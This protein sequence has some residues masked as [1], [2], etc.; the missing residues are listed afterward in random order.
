MLPRSSFWHDLSTLD[1]LAVLL[2]A[3]VAVLQLVTF[4]LIPFDGYDS[5]SHIFWIGEWQKL[6]HEGIFYPRWMPDSYG[7][8]GAPSFYFYPPLTYVLASAIGLIGSMPGV[9]I[10]KTLVAITLLAS[11]WTMWLYLRWRMPEQRA[12]AWLG[13]MIF[14]FAPYRFFN[15]TTR[16]ALSEHVAFMFVPLAFWAFDWMTRTKRQARGALLLALTFALLL[17]TNLPAA[18]CTMVALGIYAL[19][20]DERWSNVGALA[21][22]G[23]LSAAL[24]AIYL[25]PIAMHYYDVQLSRIWM[26]LPLVQMSPLIAIFTMQAVIINTYNF[27]MLAGAIVLFVYWL[28]G[29]QASSNMRWLLAAIIVLQLPVISYYLFLYVFP[30]SV[31]QLPARLSIVL[32]VIVAMAW[33]D[34]IRAKQ[35]ASAKVVAAWSLCALP[36]VIVQLL[37][38]H[39]RPWETRPLDDPPEYATRWAPAHLPKVQYQPPAISAIGVAHRASYA[40]TLDYERTTPTRATLQRAYWP[41]WNVRVDGQAATAK[42]DSIGRLTCDAPA[43]KHQIVTKLDELPAE[44]WGRWTSLTALGVFAVGFVATRKRRVSR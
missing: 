37:G 20:T 33:Q 16:A 14:M 4:V 18:A 24:A 6:W 23:L 19:A 32:L 35:K 8:L 43:G 11:G 30:F 36:L 27:L 9:V 1:R 5:T 13:A 41:A 40:D 22:S 38:V 44:A 21:A 15:Y 39:I 26:D 12:A 28:R 42:P 29:N 17:V 10:A 31:I 2:L 7:G 34:D 25:V 3:A